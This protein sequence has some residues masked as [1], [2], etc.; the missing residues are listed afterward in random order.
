MIK[1]PKVFLSDMLQA[2]CKIETYVQGLAWHDFKLDE[3]TQDAVIRQ[4]MILGEAANKVDK[5]LQQEW[6]EIPWS[7]LIGLR[8]K[9]VHDYA[10]L[11]PLR[12]WNSLQQDLP[13]LQRVLQQ[14]LQL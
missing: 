11:S 3:K 14:L 5:A 2:I 13:P 6:Q 10:G 1:D 8:N 9:L 12:I 4:L 7:Q